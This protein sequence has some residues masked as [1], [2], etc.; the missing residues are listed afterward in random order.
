MSDNY[1]ISDM[2]AKEYHA[3]KSLSKTQLSDFIKCPR[4]YIYRKDTGYVFKQTNSMMIGEAVHTL[5]L[6]EDTFSN[7]YAILPDLDRRT[8]LGKE[9]IKKILNENPGKIILNQEEINIVH[10][11]STSVANHPI[12][13][14]I[15]KSIKETE[16]SLFYKLHPYVPMRS[17]LDAITHGGYI[18]DVKTTNNASMYDFNRS[19]IKY[20]YDLQA[21]I[22]SAAYEKVYGDP[23]KGFIF[24][25][26]ETHAP[27]KVALY[28]L[29]K[30]RIDK[31]KS[32]M[33]KA[34]H[35]Y[36]ECKKSDNWPGFNNDEIT[37]L[38]E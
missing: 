38:P 22:Y 8:K 37:L 29:P 16:V 1:A 5:L 26:T 4:Q 11:I 20:G 12:A 7:R 17:R 3:H 34:L 13:K 21:C 28:Q 19:V 30:S 32:K 33:D 18:I 15:M 10:G 2:P 27:Y 24:L 35:Y 31:M 36:Y 14:D 9:E 23:P 6:E 25:C